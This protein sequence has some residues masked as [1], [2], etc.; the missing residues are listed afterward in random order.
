MSSARRLYK[1]ED[2][3][4]DLIAGVSIG[5]IT[6]VLLARPAQGLK[7]L[8]ALEAF[9]QK[10][11]VSGFF[12]PPPLRP[13]ASALGNPNFFVPRYDY[14]ALPMW[15]NIYDTAP[16]RETLSQL[17]DLKALA[18]PAAKPG[19]L[20]SATDVAA[21]EIEYF[22]SQDHGLSLDH[23]VASGSLPPSFPM[24]LIGEKYYWDGGLFDNTPLGAVLDRL[25]TSAGADR[26]I[27]RRQSVSEYSAGPLQHAGGHGADPK[28]PVRQ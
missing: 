28:P 11:T 17:V 25:D 6:A 15:T 19:L 16:L 24:T 23:I 26:T 5:A 13:Y 8:E 20:V 22:F 7:P 9:W 2:F 21:G 1:D 14:Y 18:D 3:A 4:P 10:I 12:L 27:L